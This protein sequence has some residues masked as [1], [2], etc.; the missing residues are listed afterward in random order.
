M[1]RPNF[2]ENRQESSSV[3]DALSARKWCQKRTRIELYFTCYNSNIVNVVL[4][5]ARTKARISMWRRGSSPIQGLETCKNG[6]FPTFFYRNKSRISVD[7]GT[8]RP[9]KIRSCNVPTRLSKSRV[10]HQQHH[11]WAPSSAFSWTSPR[12]PWART[13]VATDDRPTCLLRPTHLRLPVN[14]RSTKVL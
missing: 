8:E 7:P 4:A 3:L 9:A 12:P 11:I 5:K 1:S 13:A 10:I 14:H 6:G 2:I